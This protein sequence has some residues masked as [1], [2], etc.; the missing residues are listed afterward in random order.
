[1]DGGHYVRRKRGIS[2]ISETLEH[3]QLS[4]FMES[5]DGEKYKEL[6]KQISDSWVKQILMPSKEMV[7]NLASNLNTGI[8]FSMK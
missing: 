6:F 5:V 8:P 3:L 7:V 4:A 1:M 2:L